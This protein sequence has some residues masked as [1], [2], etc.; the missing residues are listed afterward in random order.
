MSNPFLDKVIIIQKRYKI[1]RIKQFINTY[2]LKNLDIECSKLDYDNFINKIVNKDILQKINIFMLRINRYLN[3]E[4]KS[5]P[6]IFSRKFLNH[7]NVYTLEIL[8]LFY[9]I[10]IK[11]YNHLRINISYYLVLGRRLLWYPLFL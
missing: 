10:L 1:K 6:R 9:L 5:V 8:N 11:Y 7:N 2:S 4:T 3:P